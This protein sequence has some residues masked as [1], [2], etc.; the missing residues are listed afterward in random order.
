MIRLK[1]LLEA[2]DENTMVILRCYK[3]GI[4]LGSIPHA[5]KDF[6]KESMTY[7]LKVADIKIYSEYLSIEIED[8]DE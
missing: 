6:N 5:I 8:I 7:S 1:D 2:I 4:E 3:G